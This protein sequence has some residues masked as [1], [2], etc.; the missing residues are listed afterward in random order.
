MP[1]G[2]IEKQEGMSAG[3]DLGGDFLQMALHG[4][5]VAARE[6]EGCAGSTFGT[7]GAEDVG[8]LGALVMR[9]AGT[10]AASGPAPGDLV[11]LADAGLVLP[12]DFY[13]RAV[14]QAFADLRDQLGEFF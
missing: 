9:R 7:D 10:A 8:R 1:P 4:L 11:L 2:L 14:G 3:V 13:V 6:H 12:P 5:G